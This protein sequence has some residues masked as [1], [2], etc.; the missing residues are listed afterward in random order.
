MI[1]NMKSALSI[2]FLFFIAGN[3]F[4]IDP[5]YEGAN[6]IKAKVFATNC[7]ACHASS[8]TGSAR[9]GAP[10]SLD[11][12]TYEAAVAN[13]VG[14]ISEVSGGGMPPSDS[15]LPLLDGDQTTALLAWQSAGFPKAS[16]ALTTTSV[17]LN[18]SLLTISLTAGANQGKGADW[19]VVAFTPWGH[20]YYYV[21]PGKWVDIGTELGG[22]RPA[23][24][25]PLTDISGLALFDTKG[26][27]SGSYTFYFG[28][29]TSMNGV[30]DNDQLYYSSFKLNA[31]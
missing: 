12:D 14:A 6:G 23:Y 13:A 27:S 3:A 21:Y 24:Q 30:L 7:L 22:A 8:V 20:W 31:P 16:T 2:L 15:G 1:V 28:V 29:D 26:V 25:G 5:V 10:G 17:G 19:W 4:A 18:G 9:N 11:F